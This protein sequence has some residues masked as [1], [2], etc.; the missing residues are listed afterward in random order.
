LKEILCV[1]RTVGGS[2]EGA[3]DLDIVLTN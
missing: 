3:Q 1:V 2:S